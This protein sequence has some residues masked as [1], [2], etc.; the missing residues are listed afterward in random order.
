MT[1]FDDFSSEE[2]VSPDGENSKDTLEFMAHIPKLKGAIDIHG[3]GENCRIMLNIDMSTYGEDIFKLIQ[4]AKTKNF[5][6]KMKPM[7]EIISDQITF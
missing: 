3:S 7:D 4:L 5:L 6:V 2:D 1:E